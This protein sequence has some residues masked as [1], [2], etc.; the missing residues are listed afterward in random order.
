M[1]QARHEAE[2]VML[3]LACHRELKMPGL[4]LLLHRWELQA[5][6]DKIKAQSVILESNLFPC[7]VISCCP[8]PLSVS[9]EEQHTTPL[10]RE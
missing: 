7:N 9:P 2:I 3:P 1:D 8:F 4:A 5:H 6:Q 10:F